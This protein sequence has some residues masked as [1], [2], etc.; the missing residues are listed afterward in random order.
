VLSRPVLLQYVW[1][2]HFNFKRHF[3]RLISRM[4]HVYARL[5][6]HFSLTER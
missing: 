5:G 6:F 2:S 1:V 3:S 4:F